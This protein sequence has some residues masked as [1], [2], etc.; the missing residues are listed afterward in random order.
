[1]NRSIINEIK[2]LEAKLRYLRAELDS[3]Y[4]IKT[5][6]STSFREGGGSG[7]SASSVE[8][9][10]MKIEEYF[11]EIRELSNQLAERR[12]KLWIIVSSFPDSRMIDIVSM[13]LR[14]EDNLKDIAE[15]LSTSERTV[16]RLLEKAFQMLNNKYND[17]EF[18]KFVD[19]AYQKGVQLHEVLSEK[20]FEI[21]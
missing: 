17:P 15:K 7:E 16:R 12:K 6:L 19:I 9:Y 11:E 1:M 20:F 5:M 14:G 2:S 4:E 3:I 10:V 18:M 13:R 21:F 8:R